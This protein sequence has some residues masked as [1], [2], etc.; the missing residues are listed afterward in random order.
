MIN[1]EEKIPV[2][3]VLKHTAAKFH[4]GKL[5]RLLHWSLLIVLCEKCSRFV[6]YKTDDDS[7][8]SLSFKSFILPCVRIC[9]QYLNTSTS[10]NA[11]HKLEEM[12]TTLNKINP[13]TDNSH[14]VVQWLRNF[15][16]NRKVA[17]SIP[18][19][20]RIFHWHNHTQPLT[21]MSTRNVSWG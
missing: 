12:S 13:N 21:E 18:D 16:T 6:Y 3:N 11:S 7:F 15:A 2:R 20:V 4:D 8:L 17:G 5:S 10:Y 19:G 1:I 14:A 9:P